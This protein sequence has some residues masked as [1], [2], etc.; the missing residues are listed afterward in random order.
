MA[1]ERAV[2]RRRSAGGAVN[3]PTDTVQRQ[4]RTD[5]IIIII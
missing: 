5:F 3:A 1:M 2:V 4:R